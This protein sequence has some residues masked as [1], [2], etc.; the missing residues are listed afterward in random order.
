MRLSYHDEVCLD[1]Y[2]VNI[3]SIPRDIRRHSACS[4]NSK[5]VKFSSPYLYLYSMRAWLPPT[6]DV[7]KDAREISS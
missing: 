5:H 3:N 4:Q 6:Y 2:A 1:Q 7:D